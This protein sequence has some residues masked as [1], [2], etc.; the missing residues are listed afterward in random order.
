[1]NFRRTATSVAIWKDK[2]LRL[3]LARA[4]FSITASLNAAMLF[5]EVLR[6]QKSMEAQNDI[7]I[8]FDV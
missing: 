4:I 1:M 3:R 7:G 8:I 2:F 5:L 6:W